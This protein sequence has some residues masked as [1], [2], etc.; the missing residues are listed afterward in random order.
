VIGYVPAWSQLHE[1]WTDGQQREAFV[2]ELE[3]ESVHVEV[4]ADVLAQPKADQFDL[5]AHIAF[6]KPIHTRDERAEAFLNYEQRFLENRSPEAREVILALLDKYRLAGV[7]EM[8]NPEVFRLSPFR[9]MGQAQGVIQRFGTIESLRQA[10][11][12][13]QQRLYREDIA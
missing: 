9:E 3:S 13:V 10:L 8:A 4:L 6:D 12:E 2:E 1:V 11:D 5:L 7:D